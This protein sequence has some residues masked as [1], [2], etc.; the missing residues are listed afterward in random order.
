MTAVSAYNYPVFQGVIDYPRI[1]AEGY[2]L[3]LDLDSSP[4]AVASPK[5]LESRA[6]CQGERGS[7]CVGA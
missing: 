6:T 2:F 5:K 1:S 4:A 7:N 3:Q